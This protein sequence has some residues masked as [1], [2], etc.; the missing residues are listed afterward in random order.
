MVQIDDDARHRRLRAVQPHADRAHP[1][2]MNLNPFLPRVRGCAGK[3]QNQPVRVH[4]RLKR[5]LHAGA[6][7]HLDRDLA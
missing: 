6:Q 5:R 1:A 3:N 4:R 2:R 7:P